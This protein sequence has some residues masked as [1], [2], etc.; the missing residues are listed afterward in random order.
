M[1]LASLDTHTYMCVYMDVY[2]DINKIFLKERKNTLFFIK[3][4][5]VCLL[6]VFTKAVSGGLNLAFWAFAGREWPL[7]F[8]SGGRYFMNRWRQI[9]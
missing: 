8:G 9:T 2:T 3:C 7:V 1:S 5:M 4:S 6:S